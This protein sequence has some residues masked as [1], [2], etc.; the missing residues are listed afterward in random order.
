[1]DINNV[2]M[3]VSIGTRFKTLKGHLRVR[4]DTFQVL[5][6]MFALLLRNRGIL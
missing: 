3:L 2:L 5:D 6:D 4:P 1:M